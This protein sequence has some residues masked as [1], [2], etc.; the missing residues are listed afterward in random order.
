MTTS[1]RRLS[2]SSAV[3]P[4]FG[5]APRVSEISPKAARAKTNK[6]TV[7]EIRQLKNA[8]SMRDL[9]LC[10]QA[11]YA[12][13]S[14]SVAT[15][16]MSSVIMMTSEL[17]EDLGMAMFEVKNFQLAV[18]SSF[19]RDRNN[20]QLPVENEDTRRK[21][22]EEELKALRIQNEGLEDELGLIS[23]AIAKASSADLDEVTAAR[24]NAQ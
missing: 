18:N 22:L 3:R 5:G 10:D 17:K 14:P 23:T 16:V 1:T 24:G 21:L 12:G 11:R 20:Q 13:M 4:G 7:S 8:L 6:S 2:P 15:A 19:D 9:E